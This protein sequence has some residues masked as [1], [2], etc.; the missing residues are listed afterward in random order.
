[1]KNNLHPLYLN[2]FFRIYVVPGSFCSRLMY[3]EGL[4][5]LVFSK[6]KGKDKSM[7]KR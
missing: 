3:T 1:M 5:I 2:Q 6:L 7:R 4:E